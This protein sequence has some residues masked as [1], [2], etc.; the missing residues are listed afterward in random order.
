MK[1]REASLKN[2]HRVKVWEIINIVLL[3]LFAFVCLYPFWNMYVAALNEGT[4]AAKGGLY[5]WPRKFTFENI[6]MAFV[7]PGIVQAL[8]V[9]FAKTITGTVTTLFCTSSLAYVMTKRQMPGTRFLSNFLFL[10]FIIPGSFIATYLLMNELGLTDTFWIF[11]I[12]GLYGYWNMIIFRA[13]FTSTIHPEIEES[14]RMDGASYIKIYF[15]LIIPL[16][17]PVFAALGLFAA[18]G[19]WNDWTTGFFYMRGNRA[20]VPLPTLLQEMINEMNLRQNAMRLSGGIMADDPV[21]RRIT[22]SSVR[23]AVTV[24]SVTPIIMV[25]PFL[26]KH[27]VKGIMVGSVKA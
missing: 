7:R 12:P 14:A 9:S 21:W 10:T 4:D 23:L 16:A 22:P 25:Y 3:S 13:Q 8:F 26:Q 20:L 5:F 19:H 17:K 24:I 27:F 2:M 18:V 1:K 11:I 15:L 6:Y